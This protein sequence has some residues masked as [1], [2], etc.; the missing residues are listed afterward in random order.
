MISNVNQHGV[1]SNQNISISSPSAKAC[2]NDTTTKTNQSNTTQ[3]T[4]VDF[5]QMSSNEM[6]NWINNQLK[7]GKMSLDESAHFLP[8]TIAI[9]IENND[10]QSNIL[11]KKINFFE[12][13]LSGIQ[14]ALSRN[15]QKSAQQL[16]A[17]LNIMKQNQS[18]IDYLA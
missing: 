15:D 8:M 7:E 10:L 11:N 16:Q 18:K 12:K 9:P 6:R 14:G 13:T 3:E 2:L 5:S 17:A 4:T 1:A